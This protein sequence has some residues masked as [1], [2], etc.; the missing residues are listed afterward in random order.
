MIR[1]FEYIFAVDNY[2]EDFTPT[3]NEIFCIERKIL[4][5]QQEVVAI[6]NKEEGY[7]KKNIEFCL[8]IMN[9]YLKDQ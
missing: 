7:R 1:G 5:N 4:G 2:K 3:R 9:Q 8:K 6:Y